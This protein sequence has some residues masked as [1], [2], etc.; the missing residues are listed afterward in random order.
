MIKPKSSKDGQW[1]K[2]EGG[3]LQRRPKAIFNILLAKVKE[4]RADIRERKNWTIQNPKLDSLVSLS[5]A[6][7]NAA[8]SL[9]RK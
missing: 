9:S 7:I 4:G 6:S 2:N 1:K 8:E 5:Q 3:N